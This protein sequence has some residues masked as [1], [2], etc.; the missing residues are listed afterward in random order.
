KTTA[1]VDAWTGVQQIRLGLEQGRIDRL[2]PGV[3][4]IALEHLMVGTSFSGVPTWSPHDVRGG[5]DDDGGG[6][7]ESY[8]LLP[9]A[10]TGARPRRRACAQ[11][12][13]RVVVAVPDSGLNTHPWFG[14]RE[15]GDPLPEDGF[16]QVYEAVGEALRYQA[17]RLDGLT[18]TQV[19]TSVWED[20][21]YTDELSQQIGRATGHFTFIAGRIHQNAPDADVLAMRVLHPDNVCYEADLLLALWMLVARIKQGGHVDVVSLS[22]GGYVEDDSEAARHLREVVAELTDLGVVLVAAAGNDSTT[23][24]FYPAALAEDNPLVLGVGALNPD[25]TEAWFSNAGAYVT[26]EATGA[27]VLSTFPTSLRGS[28]GARLLNGAGT[29]Q[30]ADPDSFTGGFAIGSGTSYAAPEVAAELAVALAGCE[31]GI[32][33]PETASRAERAADAVKRLLT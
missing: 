2:R 1:E 3:D 13:R 20:P 14:L 10:F 9:V 19:L 27:N 21:L 17:E 15:I 24:P 22:I 28:Q 16:I 11:G 7:D 23:R 30:T 8:R 6:A 31:V 33:I 29:R 18:P 12:E 5:T 4:A 25:D 26:L 32:A